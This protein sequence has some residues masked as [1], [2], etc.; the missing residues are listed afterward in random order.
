VKPSA[1]F[2]VCMRWTSLGRIRET[3]SERHGSDA[4]A[5]PESEGS[6][7]ACM[8]RGRLQGMVRGALLL[9]SGFRSSSLA[10]EAGASGSTLP[11]D[12]MDTLRLRAS[13]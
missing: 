2:L 7:K 6:R 13:M 3:A 5:A 10:S 9:V 8:G 4:P 12:A 11:T 1:V